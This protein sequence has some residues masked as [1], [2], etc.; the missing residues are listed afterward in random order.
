MSTHSANVCGAW[1]VKPHKAIQTSSAAGDN[2]HDDAGSTQDVTLEER[3]TVTKDIVGCVRDAVRQAN[4]TKKQALGLIG[5]FIELVVVDGVV[6]SMTGSCW[7]IYL[8]SL[9]INH[10]SIVVCLSVLIQLKAQ[11]ER[12]RKLKQYNG[13]SLSEP[14]QSDKNTKGVVEVG[15]SE[16]TQ[17]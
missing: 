17:Q 7:D 11:R 4:K 3:A 16:S 6:L 13:S 8:R 15:S 10:S 14:L 2:K 5:S 12:D 9:R 1:Y